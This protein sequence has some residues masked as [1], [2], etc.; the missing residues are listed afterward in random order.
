MILPLVSPIRIRDIWSRFSTRGSYYKPHAFGHI[1]HSIH[2][3]SFPARPS[4]NA[5]SAFLTVGYNGKG[6][7]LWVVVPH[8]LLSSHT[9]DVHIRSAL[10]SPALSTDG[11]YK[12]KPTAEETFPDI[13]ELA[14]IRKI[15]LRV[16]PILC[17]MFVFA[18]LD[19]INIGNAAV[20]GMNEELK[21]VGNQYNAALT[22][23]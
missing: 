8:P 16:I 15:D 9:T 13:N 3:S 11:Q 5:S 7:T 4:T 23:L 12:G 18:F 10:G 21:L 20:Y 14:L 2:P 22:I 17:L 6:E 1:I 19:R